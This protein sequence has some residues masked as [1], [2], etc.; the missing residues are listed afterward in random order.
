VDKNFGYPKGI[1]GYLDVT[2]FLAVSAWETEN[3]ARREVHYLNGGDSSWP[4]S[5]GKR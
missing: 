5:S 2:G 1:A 4:E 3:Q